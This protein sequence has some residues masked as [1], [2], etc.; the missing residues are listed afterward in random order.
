[1]TQVD[2]KPLPKRI[3]VERVEVGY[4]HT[5]LQGSCA[6]DVTA[7]EIQ[8]K[9]YHPEWGGRDAWVGTDGEG[10][11]VWGCVRHDD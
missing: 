6:P 10:N 11:T 5:R 7:K 8:E 9:F 4:A 2:K 3:M 1:M